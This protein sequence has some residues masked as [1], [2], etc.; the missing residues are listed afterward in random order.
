ML[1]H[2]AALALVAFV[3]TVTATTAATASTVNRNCTDASYR[4]APLIWTL[5]KLQ[6]SSRVMNASFRLTNHANRY[7]AV[8]QCEAGHCSPRVAA[9]ALDSDDDGDDGV[10]T[11]ATASLTNDSMSIAFNQSWFCEDDKRSDGRTPVRTKFTATASGSIPVQCL[12]SDS[13]ECISVHRTTY[14]HGILLSPA[15]PMMW[16]PSQIKECQTDNTSYI[17]SLPKEDRQWA[18]TNLRYWDLEIPCTP[19]VETPQPPPSNCPVNGV[20]LELHLMNFMWKTSTYCKGWL[21]Y[22]YPFNVTTDGAT[23]GKWRQEIHCDLASWP[24]DWGLVRHMQTWVEVVD[25]I[26]NSGG[27]EKGLGLRV[28]QSWGCNIDGGL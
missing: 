11:N 6:Y 18:S 1:P 12:S 25:V 20:G 24:A 9:T 8:I 22:W 13:G 23:S 7:S 15:A 5:E 26:R 3:T 16:M 4:F 28:E 19:G 17:S 14:I 2:R 27:D 10:S 21:R